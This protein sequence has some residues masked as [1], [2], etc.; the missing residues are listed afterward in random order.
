MSQGLCTSNEDYATYK[1]GDPKACGFTFAS[2]CYPGA[3]YN[4]GSMFREKD[5]GN[6]LQLVFSCNDYFRF[7]DI[8]LVT[9]SHFGHITPIVYSRFWK[10]FVTSSFT[11]SQRIGISS[12]EELSKT[13]LGKPER[14]ALLKK[15]REEDVKD[16]SDTDSTTDVSDYCENVI[17]KKKSYRGLKSKQHFFERR[18][19]QKEKGTYQVWKANVKP[20]PSIQVSLYLHAV[21]DSKPVYRISNRYAAQP[22]APMN[23]TQLDPSTGRKTLVEKTTSSAH[24]C[25]R[26]KM[27]FNDGS[28]RLRSTIGLSGK[29]YRSWPK[30]LLAKILED[31]IINSYANYLLDSACTVEPFTVF[32]IW[33][34]QELLESG[35]NLRKRLARTTMLKRT[36][37]R[38]SKRP[39]PG[40]DA[41]LQTGENCRGGI[42]SG[43]I[44]KLLLEKRTKKCQFCGRTKA[45]FKCRSC[46]A[47]LCMDTPREI[48]GGTKFRANGPVCFLRFHG[49]NAYPRLV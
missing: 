31:A 24:K 29:Y 5:M 49:I 6:L 40:S 19:A 32:F 44:R 1:E 16:P 20:L 37:R 14:D 45:K 10:L 25:F 11:V 12:I 41:A 8:E 23:M 22:P 3:K 48:E 33:L 2:M 36:H 35:D 28:D 9:D 30:H 42:Y 18:L 43:A 7:K 21:N 4:V 27:G 38:G 47:H 17:K 39:V 13:K 34:V 26:M 15:L 46:G